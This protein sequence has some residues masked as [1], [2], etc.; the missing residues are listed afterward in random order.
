VETQCRGRQLVPREWQDVL[1]EPSDREPVVSISQVQDRVHLALY[2][3]DGSSR[4]AAARCSHRRS[5]RRSAGARPWSGRATVQRIQR[6]PPGLE[7]AGVPSTVAE[8]LVV[9]RRDDDR[10]RRGDVDALSDWIVGQCTDL[11]QKL[12]QQASW[13]LLSC[14]QLSDAHREAFCDIL[15]VPPEAEVIQYTHETLGPRIP[16]VLLT[17]AHVIRSKIW[18]DVLAGHR[19]AV[20]VRHATEANKM[21][22]WL[23]KEVQRHNEESQ[24]RNGP[25]IFVPSVAWTA[26]WCQSRDDAPASNATG[27]LTCHNI[28]VLFYTNSLSPGMS[29]DHS[30]DYWYRVYMHVG[31]QGSGTSSMVLGQMAQRIRKPEDVVLYMYVQPMPSSS[32]SSSASPSSSIVGAIADRAMKAVLAEHPQEEEL[33]LDAHGAPTPGLKSSGL[34][35]I[36]LKQMYDRII[37]GDV[38]HA[39]DIVKYMSNAYITETDT[40]VVQPSPCWLEVLAEEKQVLQTL[41]LTGDE[42][43]KPGD[44]CAKE[45][46]HMVQ[47]P[48]RYNH[49]ANTMPPE[50]INTPGYRN[51]HSLAHAA[52]ECIYDKYQQLRVVQELARLNVRNLLEDIN[53]Y[54]HTKKVETQPGS[55]SLDPVRGAVATVCALIAM[56]GSNENTDALTDRLHINMPVV[57]ISST[58]VKIAHTWIQ[59]N[60]AMIRTLPSRSCQLTAT[61]PGAN[62]VT[63]WTVCLQRVLRE[64]TG[65]YWRKQKNGEKFEVTSLS[66]WSKLGI[67]V[68]K[69]IAWYRSPHAAQF[70]IIP[71]SIQSCRECNGAGEDIRCLRQDN[72]WKC[73]TAPSL[74]SSPHRQPFEPLDVTSAW[75]MAT[76]PSKEEEQEQQQQLVSRVRSPLIDRFLG[77]IGFQGQVG[78]GVSTVT[79]QQMKLAWSE[80]K[81]SQEDAEA[82]FQLCAVDLKPLLINRANTKN[83]L[84]HA[85]TI[86]Q[87]AGILLDLRRQRSGNKRGNRKYH[88]TYTNE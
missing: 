64:H 32:S 71:K 78:V 88:L 60:W 1:A 31:N 4:L 62:D 76:V 13:L 37:T 21:N 23:H 79:K 70:G 82:V 48:H 7:C 61:V 53:L 50:F 66:M 9:S 74:D 44:W 34:N 47:R 20:S 57:A 25:I 24:E 38:I 27:W 22:K 68:S 59:N 54:T 28:Q 49:I 67:N 52:F 35:N 51:A 29:I 83:L 56:I 81:V 85:T 84:L 65:L 46:I 12:Y 5:R 6:A 41:H 45:P 63:A 2:H 15:Q 40:T 19:V 33:Y 10:R 55:Y 17:C 14:A 3:A 26:E 42:L 80:A 87:T 16:V 30:D 77:H 11:L 72:V 73:I 18:A 8:I 43:D 58:G 39:K 75:I 36:R 69:Y 86:L